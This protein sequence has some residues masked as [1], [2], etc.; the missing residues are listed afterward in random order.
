ML[1][2]DDYVTYC[3][4]DSIKLVEGYDKE[5][6]TKY[7]NTVIERL[8]AVSETL[9]IDYDRFSPLD[10]KG[11]SHTLG[12]FESETDKGRDHTYDK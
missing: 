12:V 11:E 10:I 4:T 3:D 8:K 5:V 6:F 7:N 9:K 2:L 1:E